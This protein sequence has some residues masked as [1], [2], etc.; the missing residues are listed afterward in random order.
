[1]VQ[2]LARCRSCGL[3]GMLSENVDWPSN[4]TMLLKRFKG[5]RMAMLDAAAMDRLYEGIT[6]EEGPETFYRMEK[7][8]TRFMAGRYLSGLKGK[9]SRYGV[10]KKRVLEGMEE[11]SLL[12]G[13]GRIEMERFTPAQG[14]S[15][16]LRKPINVQLL[17]A[18]ITGV[19]EEMDR[20]LYR[21]GHESQGEN[22]F[23]LRLDAA[24]GGDYDRDFFKGRPLGSPAIANGGKLGRCNT[25]GLP[26]A[27]RGFRWDEIYGVVEAG[28]AHRRLALLPLYTLAV[29]GVMAYGRKGYG[30]R[31]LIEEAVYSSTLER[32]EGGESD[33]YDGENPGT[34]KGG[35][36]AEGTW[37]ALQV[38]G[39]GVASGFQAEGKGWRVTVTNPVDVNLLAGWLEAL[40]TFARERE[41]RISVAEEPSR[42]NY[43]LE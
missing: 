19:L 24:E 29:M 41:P 27:L 11:L 31:G 32:L 26:S 9:V 15:M 5:M 8:A 3:P 6:A 42:V 16:L 10:I 37:D 23:R 2:S 40:Y 33:A 36:P 17:T 1:M 34:L 22:T 7:G 43:L 38:R 12:L 30:T 28:A 21:P 13:M 20:C 14:G 25:C 39:W 35:I 18:G 4:G